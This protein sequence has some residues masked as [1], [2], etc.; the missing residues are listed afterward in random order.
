MENIERRLLLRLLTFCQNEQLIG[1]YRSDG[2]HV[3]LIVA[4]EPLFLTQTE[5]LRYLLA[6]TEEAGAA[7]RF[8][9]TFSSSNRHPPSPPAA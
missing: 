8:Q 9:E 3:H 1:P 7:D 2:K 4:S 5:A 6:L